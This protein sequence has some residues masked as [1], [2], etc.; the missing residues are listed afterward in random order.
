MK[1][2]KAVVGGTFDFLHDG[3]KAIL[4][5]AFEVGEKVLIGIVSNHESLEKDSSE[6]MS[7]KNRLSD[8][9]KF[10]KKRDW[11]DRAEIRKISDP[12]GPA[13]KDEDLEVIVVTE[14]TFSGAERINQMRSDNGLN[15]LDIIEL[16]LLLADDEKP[17]SSERIRSGKHR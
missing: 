14:E 5:K 3:H 9:E 13:D 17:L 15:E 1:Y 10:L 7:L 8:L 4:S 16:P 11:I 2:K 6:V 12:I